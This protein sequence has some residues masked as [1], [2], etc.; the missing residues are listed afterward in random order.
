[1]AT[2]CQELLLILLWNRK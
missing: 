1:M 2:N